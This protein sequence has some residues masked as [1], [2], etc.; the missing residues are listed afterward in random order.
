MRNL[1]LFVHLLVCDTQSDARMYDSVIVQPTVLL[2][3][4]Y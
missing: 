1:H 4:G 3:S 2:L